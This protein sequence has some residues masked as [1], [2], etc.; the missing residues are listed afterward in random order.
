MPTTTVF[1]STTAGGAQ[2]PLS[3]KG[4]KKTA[5][6]MFRKDDRKHRRNRKESYSI[7][8][9]VLKQV[10]SDTSISSKAMRVI[11]SF[12]SVIFKWTASEVSRLVHYTKRQTISSREIESAIRLLLS[13]ELV[14]LF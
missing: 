11:N 1:T 7:Y 3:K 12:I 2:G 9:K 8:N 13:Q 10:H 14:K 5:M 6:K 4:S